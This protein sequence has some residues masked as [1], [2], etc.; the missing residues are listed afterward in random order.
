MSR[1]PLRQPRQRLTITVDRETIRVI[2][3]LRKTVPE[4]DGPSAAVRYVFRCYVETQ[5]RGQDVAP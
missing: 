3:Q 2:N 5:K 4:I 1:P